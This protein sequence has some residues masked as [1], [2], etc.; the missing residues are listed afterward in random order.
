MAK[1][2]VF[3]VYRPSP[4]SVLH[5]ENKILYFIKND[6]YQAVSEKRLGPT[7][8][9][10]H[11]SIVCT[12]IFHSQIRGVLK[13]FWANSPLGSQIGHRF[14]LLMK[15]YHRTSEIGFPDMCRKDGSHQSFIF[16]WARPIRKKE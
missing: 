14:V 9:E 6:G 1:K 15:F 5:T 4:N 12:H 2:H 13:L 7:Q 8:C 10:T 3:V 16:C 11:D